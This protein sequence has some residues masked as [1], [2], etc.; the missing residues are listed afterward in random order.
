MITL[1]TK[2]QYETY[3]EVKEFTFNNETEL[4]NFIQENEQWFSLNTKLEIIK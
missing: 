3:E 4:N 2:T 1:I